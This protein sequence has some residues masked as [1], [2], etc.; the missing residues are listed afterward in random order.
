MTDLAPAA[1]DAPGGPG[2]PMPDTD[3]TAPVPAVRAPRL[4]DAPPAAR[5]KGSTSAG[6]AAAAIVV[7]VG[8]L[9]FAAVAHIRVTDLESRVAALES[10][11]RDGAV[12]SAPGPAAEPL[13]SAPTVPQESLPADTDAARQQVIAAF[14]SV[15]NPAPRVEERLRLID[16]PSGVQQA[17]TQAMRGPNGRAVGAATINVNDVRFTSAT[18]ATVI[19]NLVVDGQIIG[20]GTTGE[21]RVDGGEWKVTRA[22]VCRDLAAVGGTCV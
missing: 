7:A 2:A 5:P 3:D 17:I 22:T 4:A 9:G 21:A 6:W 18:W 1:A 15:Y 14:E 19:Y 16:D 11:V 8:A 12:A 20:M 10:A 13:T